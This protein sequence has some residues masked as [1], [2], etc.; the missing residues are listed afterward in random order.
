MAHKH[1]W[2]DRQITHEGA[3]YVCNCGACNF[4][5][6]PRDLTE[7]D[8]VA[9]GLEEDYIAGGE[10]DFLMPPY[11]GCGADAFGL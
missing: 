6:W 7:A 10:E 5:T 9:K 11:N 2:T 8:A 4:R 1:V 3:S